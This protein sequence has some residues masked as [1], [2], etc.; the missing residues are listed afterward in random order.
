M[1]SKDVEQ[2]NDIVNGTKYDNSGSAQEEYYRRELLQKKLDRVGDSILTDEDKLKIMRASSERE[3][4]E[5]QILAKLADI[6]ES[7]PEFA[8]VVDLTGT[9]DKYEQAKRLAE[10]SYDRIRSEQI[11]NF[12]TPSKEK[13][14]EHFKTRT[15]PSAVARAAAVGP[16]VGNG[17][18]PAEN[19]A[20]QL[21]SIFGLTPTPR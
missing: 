2:V 9:K 3:G 10:V 13:M 21:R 18:A 12:Y 14:R 11:L 20:D 16:I 5:L 19:L 4:I 17:P 1:S 15:L 8:Q 7:S 6:T